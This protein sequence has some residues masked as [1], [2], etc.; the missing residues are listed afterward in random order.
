MQPFQFTYGPKVAAGAGSALSLAE[1]LPRG[2]CLFVTDA[3]LRRLGLPDATLA[4]L[5]AA[6]LEAR[7]FDA[8]EADPSRET[9]L[10]AVEAGRG[11]ASV[12]GF[13]GGSPMDVAKLAAYLLGSGD[14]LEAIWGVGKAT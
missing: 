2:P 7:L 5:E 14:A 6:G 10:A 4:A 1:R 12:V 11:C 13:G 8:V 9:V 3:D